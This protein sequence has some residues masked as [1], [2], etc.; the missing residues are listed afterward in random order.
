MPDNGFKADYSFL[1][2]VY[3]ELNNYK[4]FHSPSVVGKIDG[5]FRGRKKI[6]NKLNNI[7][8]ASKV[9]SGAY[10]IT[11]Y[12]GV[13]KTSLVNKVLS[14]RVYFSSKTWK[15]FSR[16]LLFLKIRKPNAPIVLRLN[17]G[18]EE[19]K[20]K[21]ILNLIA[22]SLLEKYQLWQSRLIISFYSKLVKAI[23]AGIASYL[24]VT[25]LDINIGTIVS[26]LPKSWFKYISFSEALQQSTLWSCL[27]FFL[28]LYQL[29]RL[30]LAS[31]LKNN[32][33]TNAMA[34]EKL[35]LLNARI[36]SHL[37]FEQGA[38]FNNSI[39]DIGLGK[40]KVYPIADARDIEIAL[41]STFEYIDR[42]V[43]PKPR[44]VFVFD[45]LD[46]IEAHQNRSIEDKEEY[47]VNTTSA[48]LTRKRQQ[49]T[50]KILANLKH[51][52]TTARAK[53]IFI[54]GRE[55]YDA[56][57]ADIS[58]RNYF[59][60]SIFHD[61]IYVN[62]FLTEDP[63]PLHRGGNGF[64]VASGNPEHSSYYHSMAEEFLCQFLMPTDFMYRENQ[65]FRKARLDNPKKIKPG[66]VRKS[67][68]LKTYYLFLKNHSELKNDETDIQRVILM[69]NQFITYLAHRSSG[70][71]KKLTHLLES[72]ICSN[73]EML[74]DKERQD[75]LN[76][77]ALVAKRKDCKSEKLFL[78]FDYYSQ[79]T[80]G[81][82]GYLTVPY[83]YN[84][85]RYVR[86]YNDKLMVS[87]A[88]LIDH[89]YKF[90]DF[91][92]SWRNL[93]VTPEIIDVNK[94]P[95]LRKL[96]EDIVGFLSYT[97]LQ[98]VV[99]G[100]YDFKFKKKI[101]FEINFLSKVSERESA[102]LNFTLDES[103]EVKGHFHRTLE[104]SI[105]EHKSL[106]E[107]GYIHS[108]GFIQQSLADLH[109]YD[110][111][112]DEASIL[113]K[114]AIQQI[115]RD[116][117]EKP[118]VSLR[119]VVLLCRIM[120]K[121]GLTFER[122]KAYTSALMAYGQLAN[123]VIK[124]LEIELKDLGLIKKLDEHGTIKIYQIDR[125]DPSKSIKEVTCEDDINYFDRIFK[126]PLFSK[127][128][129][130]LYKSTTSET[131]RLLYQAFMAKLHVQDKEKIGGIT[132]RDIDITLKEIAFLTKI[133]NTEVE[134]KIRSEYHNKIG[135]L[136]HFKNYT[137]NVHTAE[138]HYEDA[139]RVLID[140][141]SDLFEIIFGFI[142][143]QTEKSLRFEEIKM[144]ASN[145]SDLGDATLNNSESGTYTFNIATLETTLSV[146]KNAEGIESEG[147]TE[148]TALK[149]LF[150]SKGPNRAIVCYFLSYYFFLI[151]DD[152][153]K[154]S[155]QCMK[156]FHLIELSSSQLKKEYISTHSS[157]ALQRMKTSLQ[158][159]E[160]V[161]KKV[162]SSIYRSYS[163]ST[164]QEIARIKEIFKII[165][166]KDLGQSFHFIL[167]NL[168]S[169]SEVQEILMIYQL[170]KL[171]FSELPTDTKG[172]KDQLTI[173]NPS[174]YANLNGMYGRLNTLYVKTRL[175]Y[176]IFSEKGFKQKFERPLG[177]DDVN[178]N[179]TLQTQWTTISL[180]EHEMVQYLIADTIY[181]LTETIRI[182]KVFG[183]SYITNHSTFGF[184]YEKRALWCEY[185]EDYNFL[186][187][188]NGV[189]GSATKSSKLYQ[190][191]RNLIGSQAMPN[192][193]AKY[194]YEKAAS[195]FTQ[196]L[197]THE[198]KFTYDRLSENMYYLED[199][200]ND[201]HL[202][203]FAAFER[204]R[205]GLGS[206]E[207]KRDD[208]NKRL[209]HSKIYDVDMYHEG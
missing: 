124:S 208:C 26:L 161:V 169:I 163:S 91:G 204:F 119:L 75:Y 112:Y 52:F 2:E 65:K 48:E 198:G 197:E 200:F 189:P 56:T 209:S 187:R 11:G 183:I 42:I 74:F 54:A 25:R 29:I 130:F 172:L 109:Y 68:S 195:H 88:Y 150:K 140:K 37:T 73:T 19:L 152:H 5:R 158:T 206:I 61:V 1:K 128:Y 132:D 20:E 173:Y 76:I 174:K 149:E 10:L 139:I 46:K 205:I 23:I 21:D 196:A 134:R 15:K 123:L 33:P 135:D 39:F 110:Q 28:F 111:Q 50:S 116:D 146:F 82:I 165:E 78:H 16:L 192:L 79:Y 167:N 34:I 154:A 99:S 98:H 120:L 17:L 97:H 177:F 70:S 191:T 153:S 38:K 202:H 27:F 103:Q 63:E 127:T 30:V 207:T 41:I 80:F 72:Y 118:E 85:S 44:F 156:V 64:Q 199:D 49:A 114:D 188:I 13:G 164:R 102:A 186:E 58:D 57:L 35:K 90:H 77:R 6:E 31:W 136:L 170:L 60:G 193:K 18:H 69:L 55:M 83:Y 159:I 115:A 171:R 59:L 133:S 175:N 4:F 66:E 95:T 7:L 141:K 121:L 93:E 185:F 105:Q 87:T 180:T 166:P 104:Y 178:G 3:V 84:I 107:T 8:K 40:K 179:T 176:E 117:D 129:N 96:I 89:L 36:D 168:P 62:S 71:P 67:V 108:K 9:K 142:K 181:C 126:E 122:K 182:L 24:M 12:R 190:A 145:L 160:A 43:F 32:I 137:S 92:F 81:L 113:Y 147:S 151:N 143:R 100:L 144:L 94:A 155:F 14:R 86:R 184:A 203:F 201:N 53:F 157:L 47:T 22:K 131:V 125:E 138:K 51:F 106:K 194:N 45:E 148:H 162:L 101:A